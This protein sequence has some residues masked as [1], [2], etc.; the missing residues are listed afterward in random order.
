[1]GGH[2]CFGASDGVLYI[3]DKSGKE[4]AHYAIGS[5]INQAPVLIGESVITADFSGNVTCLRH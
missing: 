4:I 3:I 2:L 1:M 5:P